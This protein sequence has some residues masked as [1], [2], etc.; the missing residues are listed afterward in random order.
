MTCLGTCVTGPSDRNLKRDLEAVDADQIL[1]RLS[2]LPVATW[3]DDRGVHHVGANAR[4]FRSTFG[5]GADDRAIV[6][7]D[8]D[9]VSL[10]A[11]Q[12]L[13]ARLAHLR[14]DGV[15]LREDLSRL[16][17]ELPRARAQRRAP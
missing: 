12:A 17:K 2:T 15:A 5:V 8:A 1:D 13:N 10:A 9:G 6:Q 16:R 11:L 3:T 4:D 7:V 14:E